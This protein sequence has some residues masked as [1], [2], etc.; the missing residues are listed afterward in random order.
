MVWNFAKVILTNKCCTGALFVSAAAGTWLQ[1]TS[2]S[3]VLAESEKVLPKVFF[4]VI[5]KEKRGE[6]KV[7]N[8]GR[9]VIELRS[10]VCPITAKNFKMLCTGKHEIERFNERGVSYKGTPFFRIVPGFVIQ[11]GDCKY[12]TKISLEFILF[13]GK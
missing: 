10:D 7:E 2:K 9:I 5:A 3:G 4:D 6:R 13:L 8:L 11:G 12:K 1:H